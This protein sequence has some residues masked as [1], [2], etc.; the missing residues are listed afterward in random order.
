[1]QGRNGPTP[2]YVDFSVVRQDATSPKVLCFFS[3]QPLCLIVLI[4]NL[5]SLNSFSLYIQTQ[6][7]FLP[8]SLS[9]VFRKPRKIFPPKGCWFSRAFFLLKGKTI[10]SE[11]SPK[12]DLLFLSLMSSVI[13]CIF[14]SIKAPS[15][16]SL[17]FIVC[18]TNN[19]FSGSRAISYLLT[20]CWSTQLSTL[21]CYIW[22]WNINIWD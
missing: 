5:P 21:T 18:C 20:S 10:L 9:L 14:L 3:P 2:N 15:C 7:S 6:P 11:S 1:M 8:V 19:S 22:E 16:L 12:N 4:W 17:L 13:V